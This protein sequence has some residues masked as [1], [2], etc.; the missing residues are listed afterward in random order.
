MLKSFI[1]QIQNKE[2]RSCQPIYQYGIH[3]QRIGH[4]ESLKS[5][6]KKKHL[7]R[8]LKFCNQGKD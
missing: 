6:A 2:L 1:I 7:P 3:P 4:D 5:K 8:Q